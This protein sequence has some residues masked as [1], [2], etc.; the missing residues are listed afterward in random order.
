VN[1][2][3]VN[4]IDA[5]D[6]VTQNFYDSLGRVTDVNDAEGGNMHHTYYTDGDVNET[7]DPKGNTTKHYYDNAG[8]LAKVVDAEGRY[9]VSSGDWSYESAYWGSYK[10]TDLSDYDGVKLYVYFTAMNIAAPIEVKLRISEGPYNSDRYGSAVN[11]SNA[12]KDQW[13]EIEGNFVDMGVQ[14]PSDIH[15]VGIYVS[16]GAADSD[17]TLYVDSVQATGPVAAQ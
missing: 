10:G 16:A 17:G 8:K 6:L 5:N 13:I 11:V 7:T 9:P 4:D 12:E 2:P 15:R 3:N 14:Y 1:D